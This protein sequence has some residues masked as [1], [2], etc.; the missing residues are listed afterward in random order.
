MYPKTLSYEELIENDVA[1]ERLIQYK[2][3]RFPDQTI[4]GMNKGFGP[5]ELV[6]IV[7][8][9][10]QFA[11]M[12]VDPQWTAQLCDYLLSLEYETTRSPVRRNSERRSFRRS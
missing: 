9:P 2:E 5:D 7:K 11:E 10:E 4:A 3:F 8:L 6:E 12:D 1:V